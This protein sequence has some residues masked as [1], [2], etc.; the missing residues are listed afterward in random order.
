M[1]IDTLDAAGAMLQAYAE[2]AAMELDLTMDLLPEATGILVGAYRAGW[3]HA[4]RL[5]CQTAQAARE[6]GA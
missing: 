6:H 5:L 2:T 1:D 4:G 3:E